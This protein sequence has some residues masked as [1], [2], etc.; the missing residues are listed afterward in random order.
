MDGRIYIPNNWKIQEQILYENYNSADVGHPEQQR[1]LK[2]IE[3]NY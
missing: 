1:M 3:R 2:L